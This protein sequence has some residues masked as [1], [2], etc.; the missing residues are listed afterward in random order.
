MVGAKI[1]LKFYITIHICNAWL[2]YFLHAG[3]YPFH[4]IAL[5]AEICNK[6]DKC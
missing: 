4:G 6:V 1:T 2:I 5:L 3:L